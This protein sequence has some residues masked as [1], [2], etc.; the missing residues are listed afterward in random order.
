MCIDT[1][2]L[3]VDLTGR[4]CRRCRLS[5]G[6]L[7]EGTWVVIKPFKFTS[8]LPGQQCGGSLALP[9]QYQVCSPGKW[10]VGGFRHFRGDNWIAMTATDFSQRKTDQKSCV[11]KNAHYL[12]L[13]RG[14][15]QQRRMVPTAHDPSSMR[16]S[17]KDGSETSW[18]MQRPCFLLV[19]A[20]ALS[21]KQGKTKVRKG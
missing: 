5:K 17:S 6:S 12:I 13:Y 7:H 8:N 2:K 21:V 14:I 20:V 11:A 10:Y 15:S 18:L 4:R 16:R 1:W 19:V 9:V 3:L